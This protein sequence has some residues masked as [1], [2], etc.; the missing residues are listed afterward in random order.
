[1]N[2]SIGELTTIPIIYSKQHKERLVLLEF[3]GSLSISKLNTETGEMINSEN[4]DDFNDTVIGQ[5][6][7]FD[8][9]SQSLKNP[10][11]VNRMESA[12]QYSKNSPIELKVGS[13]ELIGTVNGVILFANEDTQ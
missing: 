11:I 5:L 7:N 6:I 12:I 10:E 2:E 1:M 13:T 8:K 3:Q 9:I 4:N